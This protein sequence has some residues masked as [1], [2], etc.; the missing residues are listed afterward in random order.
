M[1]NM[2]CNFPPTL[3]L[4][5]CQPVVADAKKRVTLQ[6]FDLWTIHR[7]LL[8]PAFVH[9]DLPVPAADMLHVLQLGTNLVT[10][11]KHVHSAFH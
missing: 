5:I 4:L 2:L 6:L 7:N 8:H 3:P 9:S 11:V 10:N 1:H